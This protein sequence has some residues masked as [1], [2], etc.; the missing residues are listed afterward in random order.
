MR[1]V[2]HLWFSLDVFLLQEKQSSSA[3]EVGSSMQ[4]S[5]STDAGQSKM[6]QD[7]SDALGGCITRADSSLRGSADFCCIECA[8]ASRFCRE[9]KTHAF[10]NTHKLFWEIPPGEDLIKIIN[11]F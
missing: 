1:H 4:G 5:N 9:A 6:V 8:L 7:Q 3:V 11:Y 2:E 10:Y